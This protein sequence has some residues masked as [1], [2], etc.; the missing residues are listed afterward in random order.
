MFLPT[1]YQQKIPVYQE[2]IC[3]V[4]IVIIRKQ[5][6]ER[7]GLNIILQF[8]WIYLLELE[9]ELQLHRLPDI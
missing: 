9:L 3:G 4:V 5:G 7:K 6:R 2:V 1:D 8:R